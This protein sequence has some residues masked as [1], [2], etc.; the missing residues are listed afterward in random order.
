MNHEIR[1][2]GPIGG[3]LGYTA[4]KLIAQ[5]PEDAKEVTLRIHSPG[6]S[7]GE[8]LA[9][10]HA[11]RDHSARIITVV[12]GYAASSASFVMLAGDD[13]HVHR[14]SIVFVHNPWTYAEG[15]ADEL[16]KTADG[17]DVHA[18]AIL[19]VYK[20]RTGM[21][22]SELR[23]MMDETAFFRGVDAK[24]NGFATAVIDDKEAESQ[25]AAMLRFEGMAAQAKEQSMSRQKTRKEIEQ[26]HAE[27]VAELETARAE[28]ATAT[29]EMDALKT[30]H[31]EAIAAKDAAIAENAAQIETLVA[32][33][34]SLSDKVD[35]QKA[36]IET[37]ATDLDAAQARVVTVEAELTTAKASL[38]DPAFADARKTAAEKLATAQ[39]DAEANEAE[40]TAKAKAEAE[41]NENGDVW[42]QYY[43]LSGSERTNF[44]NEHKDELRAAQA[45]TAKEG[46]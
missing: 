40:K 28:K 25:I 11:L 1:L 43:A 42:E 35:E 16:R 37:A 45:Q 10:Y 30:E 6:G 5:I 26:A 31:A 18:E 29:A 39:A 8:G 32:A 9:M 21:D 34:K 12:D 46:E 33:G 24:E 4:E 36:L 38:A 41:E 3:F 22:E 17:L 13:R 20:Q 44:W 19:D 27:A 2:Y 7:V 23:D 14:N 15:N